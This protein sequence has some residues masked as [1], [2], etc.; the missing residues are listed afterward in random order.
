MCDDQR[1]LQ[2]LDRTCKSLMLASAVHQSR[3]YHMSSSSLRSTT[4]NKSEHRIF[5]VA[6][7]QHNHSITSSNATY[8]NDWGFKTA[9]RRNACLA[10]IV[11]IDHVLSDEL[12]CRDDKIYEITRSVQP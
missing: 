2:E 6:C 9:P 8:V 11:D 5:C 4:T 7:L 10:S 1:L 3:Y 12:W